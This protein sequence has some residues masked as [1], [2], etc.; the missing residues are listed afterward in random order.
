MRPYNKVK[1][2]HSA[3]LLSDVLKEREHQV[4]YKQHIATLKKK[5]EAV[6]VKEQ[7]RALEVA[8]MAE[9]KKMTLR[10]TKALLERDAQLEQLEAG[11]TFKYN[12]SRFVTE[13]LTETTTQLIPQKMLTLS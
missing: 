4:E 1:S 5:H 12:L 2:F 9:S 13:T 6:F 8:E 3:L 7:E 11:P 10:R